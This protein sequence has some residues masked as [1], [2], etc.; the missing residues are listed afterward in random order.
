[1]KQ[2]QNRRNFLVVVDESPEMKVA[3][4]YASLRAKKVDGIVTLLYVMT[5]IESQQWLAVE[6]SM[7]QEKLDLAHSTLERYSAEV[8]KKSGRKPIIHLREGQVAQELLQLLEEEISISVVV[9]ATST[10]PENPGPLVEL[11]SRRMASKLRVPV[12]LVPGSLSEA[13]LISLTER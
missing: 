7:K 8:I 4:T 1:M 10:S 5:P 11:L 2:S 3:L 9:L 6:E 13:E 12:T